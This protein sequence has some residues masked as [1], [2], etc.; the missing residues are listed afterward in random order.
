M[1][2]GLNALRRSARREWRILLSSPWELAV[3]TWLPWLCMTVLALLLRQGIPRELPVAVVDEAR[4]PQSHELLRLID[5]APSIATTSVQSLRDAWDAARALDVYAVVYVPRDAT[6][7]FVYYNASYPS[8]GTAVARDAQSALSSAGRLP[9]VVQTQTPFNPSRSYELYLLPLI[10]PAI[11]SFALCLAVVSAL[12]RELRDRTA[13]AWLRSTRSAPFPIVIGKMLPYVVLFSLYGVI[14]F[15][16][17]VSMGTGR[18]EGSVALLVAGW[19]LMN[20]GYAAIALL[21]VGATKKMGEGLSF[22]TLYAGTSLAY[23]TMTF[24]SEGAPLFAR[25][26]S[27]LLPY[28]AYLKLQAEQLS[29]R[30]AWQTSLPHLVALVAFIV[31]PGV[32]GMRLYDKALRDPRTWG[33]R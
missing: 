22:A 24:P 5:A 29:M 28:T 10:F 33:E 31:V 25:V 11:L 12:G 15:A 7:A 21:L 26:W 3:A 20:V 9:I 16:W 27:A 23:S 6:A 17:L 14:A 4:T 30:A 2:A 13:D 18:V 32:A 1:A 8:A 19:V